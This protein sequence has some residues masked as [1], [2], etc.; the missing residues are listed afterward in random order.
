MQ[1]ITI[2]DWCTSVRTLVRISRRAFVDIW[3]NQKNLILRQAILATVI[4]CLPYAIYW[5][6]GSAVGAL[7]HADTRPLALWFIGGVLVISLLADLLQTYQNLGQRQLWHRMEV[8]FNGLFFSKKGALGIDTL[9]N[10]E[11]RDVLAKAR[12]RRV[13]PIMQVAEGQFMNLGNAIRLSVAL[14]IVGIYD[15]RL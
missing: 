10:P 15:W 8:F 9:D 3:P 2:K 11:I 6:Y 7:A 5:F 1:N 14:G 4:A 13:W 12:E